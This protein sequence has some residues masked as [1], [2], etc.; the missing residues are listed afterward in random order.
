MACKNAYAKRAQTVTVAEAVP[1]KTPDVH[2]PDLHLHLRFGVDSHVQ[3][4]DVLQNNITE[5]EWVSRNK[6][7][8]NFWGRNITGDNCLTKEEVDFLHR[9]GCRIA[10]VYVSSAPKTT[11]EQGAAAA[12]EALT[13]VFK[14]GVR[15]GTAIWLEITEAET[16]TRDYMRGFAKT[17]LAEDYIPG[18]KAN[19]DAAYTFDREYSRGMQNDR[20]VFAPCLIWATAPTLKEYDGITTSHLIHPDNWIPFAPSAITRDGI[21]VWQYGKDC[22]PIH[23]DAGKETTFNI[24]LVK[25]DS[26]ILDKMF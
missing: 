2:M 24:N 12:A 10:P 13:A 1:V 6:L 4:H 14:L 8:P 19:T 20:E 7:Y 25:N 26:V 21:A 9:K 18:Y 16:A 23:D 15:R 22:H 3:A 17:L 11:E 5:F